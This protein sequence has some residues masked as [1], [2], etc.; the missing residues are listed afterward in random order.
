MPDWKD[1][2]GR[3]SQQIACM[4]PE[5]SDHN[6]HDPGIT[7]MEMLAWMQQNQIYHGEQIGEKHRRKYADLLGIIRRKRR[8]GRALV[9]VKTEKTLYLEEGTG[10]YADTVRFE[11]RKG[12]M[13]LEGAFKRFETLGGEP[14]TVLEGSWI[15]EGMGISLLPFGTSPEA[16]NC[17]EIT[18]TEGLRPGVRHRLFLK[19]GP[20][21]GIWDS[22]IRPGSPVDESSYDGHGYYPLAEVRMEYL[23][24]IGWQAADVEEDHTYGM[25]QDGSICFF[26]KMPMKAEDYRLRFCLERSDYLWPPCITRI[27]LAMA[28]VWQQETVKEPA[29]FFGRGLPGQKFD[30]GM[31]DLCR[32]GLRVETSL[33]EEPERMTV[34]SQVE[35]FHHSSCEDRH[36]QVEDGWILFGDGFWGRMPE[37]RIRVGG[38][39]RT[40]GKAGIVKG[41]AIT[42]MEGENPVFVLNEDEVSGGMDEETA[43]EVFTRDLSGK[44]RKKRAVLPEDYE[45]LVMGIPG[46][47]LDSCVVFPGD[48]KKREL[49]VV[50]KPAAPGGQGQLNEAYKK[51]IYRYLE[52][53]RMLGTRLCVRSPEYCPVSVLC[54]CLVRSQYRNAGELVENWIREWMGKRGFGQGISYGELTGGL[55]ALPWVL[56][57][58]SLSIVS[59]RQGRR[60]SRG[61]LLLPP[62][63]RM[64]LKQV[65]CQVMTGTGQDK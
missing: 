52:E 13:V 60:N 34:W 25:V 12:Q 46:L 40:L 24:E 28:E 27:S 4:D 19:T 48:V 49:V 32:E 18:L 16:G 50:V 65:E 59:G 15:A 7:I 22:G 23:T 55:E 54:R 3:L 29:E 61:D 21:S 45:E 20:E 11:T 53:K 62:D 38:M 58:H 36:Y 2:V 35:D 37:G 1:T 39:V 63:G 5:W 30:C 57:V 6:L 41:G 14:C 26:L 8:P 44:E 56:E 64:V 47:L 43:D 17:F 10:F 33:E 31:R 9:T 42:R 51:N